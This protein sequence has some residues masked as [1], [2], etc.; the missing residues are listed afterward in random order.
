MSLD[1]RTT[2]LPATWPGPVTPA[3]GRRASPFRRAWSTVLSLLAV[4]IEKLGGSNAEFAIDVEPRHIT[5]EGRVYANASPASSSVIVSF[6]TPDRGRL[7]FPCDTYD[8]WQDNVYAVTLTLEKLRAIDRYGV[9]QGSQYTGFKA[10]P[11]STTPTMSTRQAAEAVAR[12]TPGT[13]TDGGDA[14]AAE[15]ILRDRSFASE[16]IS[17]ALGTTH[18]DRQNGKATEFLLVGEAKRILEAHHG[19]RL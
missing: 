17:R 9:K 6:D 1:Y 2:P 16:A 13:H 14:H 10:I 8:D 11:A 3:G 18:P 5:R 12:R 4:E 19:G 15:L 7:Q